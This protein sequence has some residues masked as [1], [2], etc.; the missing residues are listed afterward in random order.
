MAFVFFYELARLRFLSEDKVFD[1]ER[2][3]FC[4]AKATQRVA[5]SVDDGLTSNIETGVYE[6]AA[7]GCFPEGLQQA[8]VSLVANFI[9]RLDS[10]GKV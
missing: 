4:G 8:I 7:T 1:H 5:R 10:G 3:H 6:E 2:V 9:Y